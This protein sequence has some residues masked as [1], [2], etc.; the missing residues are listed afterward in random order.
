MPGGPGRSH[1]LSG[2]PTGVNRFAQVPSSRA[3]R[4]SIN[5]HGERAMGLSTS[6]TGCQ[7]EE[8]CR[9]RRSSQALKL[10][11]TASLVSSNTIE[12]MK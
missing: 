8:G 3:E 11:S 12:R 1:Y 4:S 9:V 5:A 10:S 2:E 6:S 7:L